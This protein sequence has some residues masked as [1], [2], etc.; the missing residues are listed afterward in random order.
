MSLT[1]QL[2]QTTTVALQFSGIFRYLVQREDVHK[3]TSVD[4]AVAVLKNCPCGAAITNLG[5]R[6][7][8]SSLGQGALEK[9][10]VAKLLGSNLE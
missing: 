1:R 4:I 9:I 3:Y 8:K 6:A 5:V 7:E 2:A 10:G